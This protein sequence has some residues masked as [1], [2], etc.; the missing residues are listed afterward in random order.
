M[1]YPA[2]LET[3]PEKVHEEPKATFMEHLE[4]LRK[5]LFRALLYLMLGWVIG[6]AIEPYVYDFL[7]QP[8][9]KT[10]PQGTQFVFTHAT[11]PF[12]LKFKLSLIIGLI[13]TLPL[14]MREVWGFIAPGLTRQERRAV[15]FVAPFSALL[16]FVGIGLGYFILP[17]AFNFFLSYLK[18]YP[19][20][21]LYQ[22]PAQYVLFVVKMMFAFG[23]GFQMPIVLMFL[24]QVGIATPEN[25]WRSWRYA[26]VGIVALAALITPSGDAFSMLAIGIPMVF[27]YF[28]SIFLVARIAKKRRRRLGQ[29]G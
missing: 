29:R 5:R 16:F 3:P 9:L 20:A 19:N 7:A 13:L 17:A 6:F 22:N 28:L 26:V 23:L 27:L 15:L 10:Q 8:L 2:D 12:F 11:E 18:D 24:A 14:I 21:V 1:P 25:M 4:E